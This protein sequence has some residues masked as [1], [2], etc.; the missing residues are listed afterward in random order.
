[1]GN[2]WLCS[3]RSTPQMR[4]IVFWRVAT[5]SIASIKSGSVTASSDSNAVASM[6]I[7]CLRD[8]GE[9]NGNTSMGRLD[10]VAPGDRNERRS[11]FSV[12]RLPFRFAFV[13]S[14]CGAQ[15]NVAL[16]LFGHVPGPTVSGDHRGSTQ[17][18]VAT[19]EA[20]A[21]GA[22]DRK[23]QRPQFDVWTAARHR[24]VVEWLAVFIHQLDFQP[25]AAAIDFH[26][27][28]QV[29]DVAQF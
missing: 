13:A 15:E 8:G 19:F 29:A 20:D 3:I 5:T 16:F 6:S 11:Q 10:A 9:S 22:V 23:S 21:T 7:R 28:H 4:A 12:P 14:Q 2:R 27:T 18:P 17:S 1:M 26:W 24:S 25:I